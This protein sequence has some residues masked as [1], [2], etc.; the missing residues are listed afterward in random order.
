MPHDRSESLRAFILRHAKDAAMAKEALDDLEPFYAMAE[1]D[2]YP[3]AD[4]ASLDVA[5][6]RAAFQR[7]TGRQLGNVVPVPSQAS[8]FIGD[9]APGPNLWT[10]IGDGH[11]PVSDVFAECLH[12]PLGHEVQSKLGAD[13]WQELNEEIDR[14]FRVELIRKLGLALDPSLSFTVLGTAAGT[15]LAISLMLGCVLLGERRRAEDY[16]AVVYHLLHGVVP[17]LKSKDSWY[18]LVA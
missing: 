17:F 14:S 2:K 6:L 4:F 16:G 11:P 8:G 15:F 13:R 3:L 7:G 12:W 1:A 18:V 5:E 10:I 9:S